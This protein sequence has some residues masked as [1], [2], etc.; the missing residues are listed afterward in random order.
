MLTNCRR[1]VL[2]G[3]QLLGV[4]R[5]GNRAYQQ[6]PCSTDAFVWLRLYQEESRRAGVPQDV[7]EALWWT[8][9]R[10]W[11]PLAYVSLPGDGPQQGT[12]A[13]CIDVH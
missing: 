3:E 6:L 5:K 8:L 11:R 13:S 1:D 10:P 4:V 7:D 2:P 9:R 12:R